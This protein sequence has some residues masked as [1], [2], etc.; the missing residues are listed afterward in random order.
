[1]AVTRDGSMAATTANLLRDCERFG[2]P[3]EEG[4]RYIEDSRD[5]IARSWPLEVQACGLPAEDLPVPSMTWLGSWP[6]HAIAL[7]LLVPHPP[8]PAWQRVPTIAPR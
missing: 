4:R 8:L 2:Y 7:Y 3:A 6:T 5:E 1:M